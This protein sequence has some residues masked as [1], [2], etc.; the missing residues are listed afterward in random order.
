L[1]GAV[2]GSWI[3]PPGAHVLQLCVGYF[4]APR[5]LT[6]GL[7]MCNAL[8]D[9][10]KCRAKRPSLMV[11]PSGIQISGENLSRLKLKCCPLQKRYFIAPRWEIQVT[12]WFR[13]PPRE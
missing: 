7:L 12:E 11:P 2:P 6:R 5:G 1:S 10:S 13:Q 8:S 3:Y 9:R 4:Y